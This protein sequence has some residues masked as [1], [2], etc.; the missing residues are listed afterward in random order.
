VAIDCLLVRQGQRLAAADPISLE[1]IESIREKETVTATLRRA[2]NP[3]HHAKL[4]A[5]LN[6]VHPHQKG[7]PTVGDLLVALKVST[8]LFDTVQSV[9][10]IPIIIPKSI[11]FASMS[12]SDF[13]QWYERAIDVILT[14]ILPNVNKDELNDEVA[15]IMNGYQ[16]SGTYAA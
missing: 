3:R 9:D 15:S 10:R 6:I 8:G 7:Y 12:Q 13:E 11:S 4:F 14:R 2:R 16:N 5:L 1:A